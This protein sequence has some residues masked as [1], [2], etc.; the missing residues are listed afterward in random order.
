M[1][2]CRAR[3]R[4][5]AT[6]GVGNILSNM[7]LDSCGLIPLSIVR[8]GLTSSHLKQVSL[9]QSS[10]RIINKNQVVFYEFFGEFM[11]FYHISSN[12]SCDE[13]GISKWDWVILFCSGLEN[14]VSVST[15]ETVG[16][17]G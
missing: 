9:Q 2:R 15:K 7:W 12:K 1:S 3:M 13:E 17:V 10:H 16:K 6:S 11:R 8:F 4:G 5:A 14:N